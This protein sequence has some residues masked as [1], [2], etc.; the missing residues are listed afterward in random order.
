MIINFL[1]SADCDAALQW[2]KNCE[3]LASLLRPVSLAGDHIL[4]IIMFKCPWKMGILWTL[5]L[6]RSD[7]GWH[8]W[9]FCHSCHQHQLGYFHYC[10]HQ[11]SVRRTSFF[12]FSSTHRCGGALVN[13]Y[14]VATAGHCVDEWVDIGQQAKC[15]HF[16]D[17]N[18]F[19]LM[20]SQI[21]VRMG[22]WDFSSAR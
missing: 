20:I 18:F 4:H 5:C 2:R 1:S 10:C 7:I 11:V 21:R 13:E 3:R 19:S 8:C 17:N 6:Q 9:H 15:F 16:F 22:E 12:G 14:W